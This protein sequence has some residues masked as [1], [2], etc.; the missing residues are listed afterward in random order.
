MTWVEAWVDSTQ[1]R[2]LGRVRYC[3]SFLG[4]LRG[5]M[6]RRRLGDDEGLLLVG[7][8]ESRWDAAIHMLFVLFP[9]AAVW[10]D[11]EG[12]VVDSQLARPFRPLYVPKAPAQDVLEGPPPLLDQVQVGDRL[13]FSEVEDG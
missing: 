7:Q 2:L 4:R 13:C 6:L 3:D 1:G 12:Y 11:A 8:R 5:L 9:I 10:L